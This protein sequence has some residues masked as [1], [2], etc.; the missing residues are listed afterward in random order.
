MLKFAL[1]IL[2]PLF[3]LVFSA[4]AVIAKNT[5]ESTAPE[6]RVSRKTVAKR[7]AK[8]KIH[9]HAVKK[10]HVAASAPSRAKPAK[11]VVAAHASRA[12][13][14]PIV[15]APALPAALPVSSVG[16]LAGLNATHDPL[17][18]K[19]NVALVLDQ[20][21]SE[22]LF[23]KNANVSLPIASI[24]KLMTGMV[25]IEAHQNMDEVLEVTT[26]D[27][28]HERNSYSR[29]RIG[30]RLTRANM[31]HIAL[32]S[33]ENRAAS[34]LGRNYPGGLPAFVAAMNAKA[35]ALGMA[36]THY[37]DSTGL[38][39]SNV[40]SARDLAKLVIAAHAQP[41]LRQY[42]TDSRYAVNTGRGI[43]QY[44]N[45]NHLVINPSWD[46]GLQKTGYITEAGRCLVMQAIIK[47]RSIVMVFLDSKGTQSRLADAGRIRKWLE[48]AKPQKLTSHVTVAAES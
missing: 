10:K 22:V 29:L 9:Q 43:L 8:A 48:V 14:K 44:A 47:G 45:S 5:T 46:I 35:K 3:L 40:A 7:K 23:E 25:V 19:S 1:G 21:N 34:A 15:A 30:S 39:S 16:D 17:A 20:S 18:L 41:L 42:S 24:T 6:K 11:K 28:D 2:L 33:S 26:D 32:M 38:S 13:V 36:D 31:L 27:I 37:V 4:P 12:R